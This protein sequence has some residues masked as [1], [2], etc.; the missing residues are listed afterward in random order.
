MEDLITKIVYGL[1][2][3][4]CT[5]LIKRWIERV[6][7][8]IENAVSLSQCVE[9]RNE[10]PVKPKVE[11]LEKETEEQWNLLNHHGHKGLKTSDENLVVRT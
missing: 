6:G 1:I 10:C 4:V 8:K 3:I 9:K 5:A 7:N 11:R 2:I